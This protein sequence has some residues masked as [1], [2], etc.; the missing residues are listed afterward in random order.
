LLAAT[1]AARA[2]RCERGVDGHLAAAH[3]AAAPEA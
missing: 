2:T 1:R 3:I